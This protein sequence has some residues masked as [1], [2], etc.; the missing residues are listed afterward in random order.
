MTGP[1][2]R[3]EHSMQLPWLNFN[4]VIGLC[5]AGRASGIGAPSL[6]RPTYVANDVMSTNEV[7][8]L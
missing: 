6:E 4:H 2:A 3:A 7:R 1:R 8:V 5:G